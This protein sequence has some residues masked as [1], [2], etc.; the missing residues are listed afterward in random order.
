MTVD[1]T[2]LDVKEVETNNTSTMEDVRVFAGDNDH[3]PSNVSYRNLVWESIP[4]NG[5]DY[6]H[7]Y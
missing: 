5:G 3:I 6:L 7:I 2:W 1:A 4:Y